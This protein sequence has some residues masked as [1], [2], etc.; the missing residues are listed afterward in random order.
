MIAFRGSEADDHLSN[1][2]PNT[3]AD[4]NILTREV[5]SLQQCVEAREGQPVEGLDHIDCLEQE[6]QTLSLTLSIQSPSTLT[7]TEPF[8]EVV[9]QYTET[10][11]A[12]QKQTHLINSLLQDNAI[13]NE[14]N[15]TKLEEWLMDIE[16]AADLTS[17]S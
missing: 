7:P 11:C 2:L 1:L 9:C 13:F 17:E 14:H 16:K 15:S 10:L 8:V 3:Q 5:H 6:P 12:M 4:L